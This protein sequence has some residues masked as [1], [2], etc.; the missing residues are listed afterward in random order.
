MD[1]YVCDVLVCALM[2]SEQFAFKQLFFLQMGDILISSS[3]ELQVLEN[4]SSG[5]SVP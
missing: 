3:Y 4:T 2:G 1:V 5:A